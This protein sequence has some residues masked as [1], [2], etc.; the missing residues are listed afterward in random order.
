MAVE[1]M[2]KVLLVNTNTEKA[3]YPVPPLGLCIIASVIKNEHEVMVYDGTFDEGRA[4]IG[5]LSEFKPDYIGATI[6]N[7]DDMDVVNP[8]SY[9]ESI[10]HKFITP[11]LES[12]N[13]P[14]ILGGSGFSILPEF[15][16]DHYSADYGVAGEGEIVFP[17]LLHCLDRGGDPSAVAGVFTRDDAGVMPCRTFDMM[18]LPFSEIDRK[19]DYPPY[20]GRGSYP[21]QTKR[22]CAH[23]CVYCTYKRIEGCRYRTRPPVHI[24]DEIEQAQQRLGQLTF[25]FVDSTFNDPPGHAEGICRELAVR[26]L[27]LRLRT[28]GINPCN[29]TSELFDLMCL[30]GFA[31]IDCTPDT[32]SSRMLASL[33]KNFKLPDLIRTANLVREYDMPTMWFFIFGGP[34]ETEETIRET[35]AFID[36]CVSGKDMV[37]MT[38]GLRIYPGTDLHGTALEEKMIEPD[39][40]LAEACFYFSKELGR[41]RLLSIIND[42][43]RARPNCVPVAE[44]A[45]S[46]KMMSEAVRMREEMHLNEPLF[47]TL[48][49]LRY[50][51]L[52][53]EMPSQ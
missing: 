17:D 27:S 49:R 51:M 24:A 37:H 14:L 25:E 33:K 32:A 22:G 48:L 35:F 41:D 46:P 7:I 50:R 34:G 20:R 8:T 11:I 26:K 45:P 4:L 3:P 30:S 53:K 9:I 40:M 23:R 38:C 39:D 16:L 44:T 19:I 42:A 31:Q 18:K 47:R 15:Y 5:L 21:I 1:R 52:G 12:G 36:S 28:M 10:K 6:R 13:A 43:S 29:A 2:S